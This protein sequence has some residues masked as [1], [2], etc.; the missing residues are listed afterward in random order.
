MNEQTTQEVVA[1]DQ[2]RDELAAV[3]FAQNGQLFQPKN[4]R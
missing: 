2:R 1:R 4:G 3:D